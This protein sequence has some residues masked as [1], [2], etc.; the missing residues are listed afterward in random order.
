[1]T[2]AS[3]DDCST[4]APTKE[5]AEAEGAKQVEVQVKTLNQITSSSKWGMPDM[6]KF[7]A[8]RLI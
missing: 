8:E 3:R 4:F 2:I 5:E 1:L 6:I 7:D